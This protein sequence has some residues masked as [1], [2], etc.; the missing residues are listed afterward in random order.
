MV[1]GSQVSPAQQSAPPGPGHVPVASTQVRVTTLPTHCAE[2][3][4]DVMFWN[5][6]QNAG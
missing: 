6:S 2:W 3:L 1:T 4:C 5:G